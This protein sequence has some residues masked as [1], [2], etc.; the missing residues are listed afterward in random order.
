MWGKVFRYHR[1]GFLN[2][3]LTIHL[4]WTGLGRTE[5]SQF[6][7]QLLLKV[8]RFGAVENLNLLMS[9]SCRHQYGRY[10]SLCTY[11]RPLH[12]DLWAQPGQGHLQRDELESR[13]RR[14]VSAFSFF[15]QTGMRRLRGLLCRFWVQTRRDFNHDISYFGCT[16]G[17]CERAYPEACHEV[18]WDTSNYRWQ[19]IFIDEGL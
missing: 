19:D 10:F 6:S 8:A 4:L 15:A 9:L 14:L 18:S 17:L 2:S 1:N 3:N 12:P 13:P 7:T 11:A 5:R 16:V